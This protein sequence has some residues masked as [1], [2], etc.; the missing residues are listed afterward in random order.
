MCRSDVLRAIDA[1]EQE[2]GAHGSLRLLRGAKA[3]SRQALQ[4]LLQVARLD[5]SPFCCRSCRL[6]KH[7]SGLAHCMILQPTFQPRREPIRQ[8]D[9]HV[10]Q[11]HLGCFAVLARFVGFYDVLRETCNQF[12]TA[13]VP[14]CLQVCRQ[15]G[16]GSSGRGR[17]RCGSTLRA[18]RFSGSGSVFGRRRFPQLGMRVIRVLRVLNGLGCG[19]RW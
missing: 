11:L 17:S 14:Y 18:R 12:A 4:T 8:L 15:S 9:D 19:S 10:G 16:N 13:S 1:G 2:K 7:M 6:L 5:K 3:L